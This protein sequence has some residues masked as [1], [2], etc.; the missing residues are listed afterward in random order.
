M[1]VIFLEILVIVLFDFI[2]IKIVSSILTTNIIVFLLA[3][4]QVVINT[5]RRKRLC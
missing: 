1:F 3:I 5:E 4:L 2:D